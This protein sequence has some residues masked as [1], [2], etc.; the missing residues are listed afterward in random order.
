MAEIIG[1][2]SGVITFADVTWKSCKNLHD[3]IQ[4]IK[5]TPSELLYLRSDLEEVGR[6]LNNFADMNREAGA[7]ENVQY[8]VALK[9]C[10]ER[11]R[12]CI[13][14]LGNTCDQFSASLNE[15]FRHS[16]PERISNRDR[17]SFHF[18]EG[19]IRRFRNRLGSYK[20]TLT[21]ALGLASLYVDHLNVRHAS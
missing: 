21:V 8:R 20:N 16:T 5:E 7:H 9:Q 18:Q 4:D 19:N 2:V 10:L 15:V 3:L 1:V 17:F 11:L 13:E 14:E 6:I 12:P